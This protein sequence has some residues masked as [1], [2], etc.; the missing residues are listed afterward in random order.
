MVPLVRGDISGRF[1]FSRRASTTYDS[2]RAQPTL[3]RLEAEIGEALFVRTPRKII[4]T[5]RGEELY[6]SI[7]QAVD[8]LERASG[9]LKGA[10]RK[11][12]IRLGSAIEFFH[13]R[14]LPTIDGFDHTLIVTFGLTE[15]LIE[16]LKQNALDAVIATQKRPLPGI[17]YLPCYTES[18]RLVGNSPLQ[19]ASK[20]ELEAMRWISYGIELPIIRRFWA[21]AFGEKP[22]FYP[23]MVIP[24]LRAIPEAVRLGYGISVLPD[25]LVDGLLSKGEL[26]NGR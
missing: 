20:A 21:V 14:L 1:D 22:V 17:H 8:R 13:E 24:D 12:A 5:E 25:Y 23:S 16:Q 4:P 19:G 26:F 15:K 10:R 7:S 6:K 2:A 11:S 3:G 9:Q 18:F